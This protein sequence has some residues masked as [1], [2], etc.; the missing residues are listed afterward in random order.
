LRGKLVDYGGERAVPTGG[1]ALAFG[2][3]AA[4]G[5]ARSRAMVWWGR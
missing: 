4:R 3:A 1:G 2:P 5:E